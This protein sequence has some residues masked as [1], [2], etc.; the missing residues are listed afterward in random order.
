MRGFEILDFG[1]WNLEFRFRIFKKEKAFLPSAANMED[2]H[3]WSQIELDPSAEVNGHGQN[4]VSKN[5]QSA[6]G[7]QKSYG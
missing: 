1:F 2:R 3:E 5:R 4:R 7:I 6:F